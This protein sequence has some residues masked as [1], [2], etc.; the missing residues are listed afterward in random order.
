MTDH[1][2]TAFIL[3]DSQHGAIESTFWGTSRSN[4]SYE[5]NVVKLLKAFRDLA[6]PKGPHIIHIYHSSVNPASPLFPNS[7]GMAFH[8]SSLPEPPEPVF[9][10]STNSAFLQSSPSDLGAFLK[11]N[12][13]WK[14]YFA[15]LSVDLCL[16]STIRH[17]SDLDVCGHLNEE[18]EIIK[19]QL[20]LIEDATAAW[21][22]RGGK[23]DAETIQGVH[24]ESLKGEFAKIVTSEE[25]L[26]E[27]G[28]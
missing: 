24:V 23:F 10:K 14:V 7:D 17:A 22:K 25:V 21:A 19:G 3:V 16:G 20:L 18:G 1:S 5:D 26:K 4:P 6:G 15:G 2:H 13:I 27:L 28:I 12:Q 9:S 11:E 8:A